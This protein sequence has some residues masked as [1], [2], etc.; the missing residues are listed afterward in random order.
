VERVIFGVC[1]WCF[2]WMERKE[3]EFSNT[4]FLA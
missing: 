4:L 1:R 3:K 2:G